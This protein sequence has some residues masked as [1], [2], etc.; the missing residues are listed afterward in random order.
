MRTLL[1]AV[2]ALLIITLAT[3]FAGGTDQP[4]PVQG[5]GHAPLLGAKVRIVPLV[6]NRAIQHPPL[7]TVLPEQRELEPRTEDVTTPATPAANKGK[8]HKNGVVSTDNGVKKQRLEYRYK[9]QLG[10]HVIITEAG[11][12]EK[13]EELVKRHFKAIRAAFREDARID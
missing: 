5:G 9:G 3:A 8:G 2:P 6:T 11:A 13:P 4:T 1:T 10:E 7:S 12:S